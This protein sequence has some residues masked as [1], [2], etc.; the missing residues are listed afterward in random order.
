MKTTPV[1]CLALTF[2]A[3]PLH[4]QTAPSFPGA[5]GA[6]RTTTGG[7]GGSVIEV[8]T[9]ADSGTGSF[10]A[11]CLASG[12]RTIVFR[13]GGIIQLNSELTIRNPDLTIAGQTAPGDG[14]CIRGAT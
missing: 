3:S 14:I 10:R 4:A 9:L 2:L 13:V 5:E 1:T 8:T 6:G 12:A 7:R 11:A